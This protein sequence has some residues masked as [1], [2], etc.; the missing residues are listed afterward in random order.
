MEPSEYFSVKDGFFVAFAVIDFETN[1]GVDTNGRLVE[2]LIQVKAVQYER[3]YNMEQ[4]V[5]E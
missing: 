3:T 5:Y 1:S 4:D 2:D